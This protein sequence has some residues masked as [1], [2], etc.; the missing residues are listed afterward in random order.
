MRRREDPSR[1]AASEAVTPKKSTPHRV[2]RR[3]HPGPRRIAE[4]E[5]QGTGPTVRGGVPW[6]WS[7]TLAATVLG[8]YLLLAPPV[9][10]DKDASE[11]VLALA[12]GGV[13][14]PTGY[15]IYTLL[16]HGFV[17]G[18]HRLGAGF[19]FAA[20][21]WSALG[22]GIAVFL[23]HR[24]ALRLLQVHGRPSRLERFILAALPVL[25]LGFNPVWLVEC[26]VVEVHSWHLAWLCGSTLFFV[27][28]VDEL[29][30]GKPPVRRLPRRLFAWGL[31]CGLGG[32]HHATA[33]FFAAG[34]TAALT[35]ALYRAGQFR[36]WI[37][38]LWSASAALPLLSYAYLFYRTGHAGDAQVWP[39]L[40]PSLR[41]TLD[42]L[43]ARAYRFYLG[44]F[45]PDGAQ[46]AWLRWYVHPYLWTGLSG[47][48]V[49]TLRIRGP[50]RVVATALL[51]SAVV[52]TLFAFQ[53]GVGDPDAYFL[54]ALAVGLLSVALWGGAALPLLKRTRLG[55]AIA[56]TTVAL[57]LAAFI[58][59]SLRVAAGRRNALIELDR[60]VHA[61]WSAIPYSR[62]IV[63]W[64]DDGY[65]R[66][67]EYQRFLGE[68]PRLEVYHTAVLFD[69]RQR[70]AFRRS[71]GF[72]PLG[73]IDEAHRRQPLEQ[74][75][76]IG[77]QRSEPEAH[78]FAVVH[79][80][81]AQKADVPV[82][83]FD[84]PG[85][86]RVLPKHAP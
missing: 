35:W 19:A 20:N 28:L 32:A 18:L 72:D 77:R 49:H 66:L 84:P 30:R 39:A 69:E 68:K 14:H 17:T 33:V 52:Q 82:I 1:H 57:L 50:R 3:D 55:S 58:G 9:P 78:A 76:V 10:G 71:H 83:A 47:F 81:I 61:A 51:V 5:P 34:L 15:P 46:A 60:Q 21:A 62:G 54:P 23:Y 44:H 79:E 4:V 42:H 53:Y 8:C 31:L 75:Y 11:F 2:G 24:L 56:A 12:T 36:S 37:P 16:G 48:A 67:K 64:P 22:G 38:L 85:A 25:L 6:T 65:Y 40:V 70:M 13:I 86:P 27:G 43:T 41:G 59:S 63:L 74:E 73:A 26:T 7:A 29:G 80:T 45:A